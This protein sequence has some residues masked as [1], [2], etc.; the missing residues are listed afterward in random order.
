MTDEENV[1]HSI[2]ARISDDSTLPML[3]SFG[4]CFVTTVTRVSN[5]KEVEVEYRT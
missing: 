4:T 2:F 1:C 3:Y 5:E